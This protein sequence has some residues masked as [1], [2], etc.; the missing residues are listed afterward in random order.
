MTC[1]LAEDSFA[2]PDPLR[3]LPA[4]PKPALAAPMVYAGTG[5]RTV[6]S[7][8]LPRWIAGTK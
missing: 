8:E 4:P 5:T 6:H 7:R 1:T 2:L 3:N